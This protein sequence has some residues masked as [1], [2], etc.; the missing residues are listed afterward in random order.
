MN[1][2]LEQ[3]YSFIK[4]SKNDY[5]EWAILDMNNIEDCTTV[6]KFL[7]THYKNNPKRSYEYSHEFIQWVLNRPNKLNISIAILSTQTK[8]IAGFIS[9]SVV[10]TQIYSD[11]IDMV[12]C[13]F[14]C[15]HS[16]LQGRNV[17]KRLIK[18]LSNMFKIDGY[19]S[20]Y[21]TTGKIIKQDKNIYKAKYYH[22]PINVHNYIDAGL[23][24]K[25]KNITDDI[26]I[27]EYRLPIEPTGPNTNKLT[28]LSKQSGTTT[29]IT[30][31]TTTGS[32]EKI[33]EYEFVKM[34]DKHLQEVYELLNSYLD[35]YNIY[36]IFNYDEFVHI[37]HN[38]SII[39]SY[40][41][42][43]KDNQESTET[44]IDFISYY[45]L[46]TV[47]KNKKNKENEE[48]KVINVA[49]LYY[50]TSTIESAYRLIRNMMIISQKNNIDEF[51]IKDIMENETT[52]LDLGFLVGSEDIHYHLHNHE[53]IDLQ[54]K[55][56]GLNIVT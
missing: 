38:N 48:N 46:P 24:R 32:F 53:C 47:I 19:N 49:Y 42:I 55:Q 4:I 26:I 25:E 21:Y 52:I 30:T 45:T 8:E 9:G 29:A 12:Q 35:K 14:M 10:K 28:K 51:I 50:Y 31:T 6:A 39:T 40:V 13:N 36:H 44:V 15:V 11:T 22:R 33:K 2:T 18:Q 54:G 5:Y 37:F 34:T 56:I 3:K 16:V 17:A 1:K 7:S 41:L 20:G 23:L 27:E 43:D